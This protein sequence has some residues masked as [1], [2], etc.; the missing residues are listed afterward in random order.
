V[1]YRGDAID[2]QSGRPSAARYMFDIIQPELAKV[3]ASAW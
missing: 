1:G 2:A 3:H